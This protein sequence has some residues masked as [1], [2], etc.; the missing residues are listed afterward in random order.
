MSC[1]DYVITL[2]GNTTSDWGAGSATTTDTVMWTTGSYPAGWSH[3]HCALPATP[4]KEEPQTPEA[5]LRKRVDEV[6]ELVSLRG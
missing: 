6:C 5:W 4:A 2:G 3:I 1:G